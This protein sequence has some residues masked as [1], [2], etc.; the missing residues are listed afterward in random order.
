[1][2]LVAGIALPAKVLR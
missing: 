2:A 1:V